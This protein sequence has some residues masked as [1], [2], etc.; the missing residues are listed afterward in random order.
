MSSSSTVKASTSTLSAGGES[1][2][3]TWHHS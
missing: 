3:S 1:F 2:T